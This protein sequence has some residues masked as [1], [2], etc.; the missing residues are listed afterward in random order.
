MADSNKFRDLSRERASLEEVVFGYDAYKKIAKQL[1]ESQAMIQSEKDPEFQAYLQ[2]EQS[3]LKKQLEE[4]EES[5]LMLLIPKDP[6]ESKNVLV[7][8]RAGTGGDEAAL[9]AAE[10]FRMY[11][12]YAERHKWKTELMNMNDTGL[13]GVKEAIFSVQGKGAWGQL[14]HESGVHRVQRVPETEAGGRIHTSTATVAVLPEVEDFEVVLNPADLKLDTYR[15]SGAG[16]QHVNKTE[17]AVRITHIPTG[18]VVACQDERSQ[19][20]NR[21]KAMRI[22]RAHLYEIMQQKQEEEQGKLRREQVGT[23]E[24]SEKIRTYNFPQSRITDHRIGESFHNVQAFMDGDLD[25]ILESLGRWEKTEL[26][27]EAAS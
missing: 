7:E 10:L 20:Q 27:K 5:L 23:G 11:T 13:G 3:S 24:R 16:G 9:F 2:T 15:A 8:I 1:E 18:F 4:L 6:N 21:E 14:K 12:R 19:H 25:D 26:L 22:L 17:S